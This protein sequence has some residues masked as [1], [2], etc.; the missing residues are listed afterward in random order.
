MLHSRPETLQKYPPKSRPVKRLAI[1]PL[2]MLLLLIAIAMDSDRLI[3]GADLAEIDDR[4]HTPTSGRISV[5]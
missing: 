3:I 1:R 5:N 4:R 2:L